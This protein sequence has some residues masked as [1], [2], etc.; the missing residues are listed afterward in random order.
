[1]LL[2]L[3]ERLVV[4]P[5]GATVPVGQGSLS[6]VLDD[7]RGGLVFQYLAPPPGVD[8]ASV[9]W[10][11]AGA[12]QPEPFISP[13]RGRWIE[14]HDVAE[15]AGSP[16]VIATR[17]RR[18]RASRR[19]VAELFLFDV[20]AG[21]GRVAFRLG[22]DR[23]A[24]GRVSHGG[25]RF[26]ISRGT[27]FELRSV[28][29]APVR[30]A[31]LPPPSEGDCVGHGVL[32]P[33]GSQMVYVQHRRPICTS[34]A[35]LVVHDL[36]RGEEVARAKVTRRGSL[37]RRVEFDGERLLVSREDTGDRGGPLR[38]SPVL[39]GEVRPDATIQIDELSLGRR[40]VP[41]RVLASFVRSSPR[42]PEGARLSP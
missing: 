29:G 28:D 6:L 38:E 5:G 40:E 7:L 21:R 14:L 19:F 9:M 8:S 42:I 18:V 27:G 26:L 25:G 37:V 1:V 2:P 39:V 12:S 16:T 20:E 35:R 17:W 22:G 10:L 36:L 11:Q 13:R 32:S 31:S 33:D 34:P 24:S 23:S 41:A 15:M 4:H 30:D 3:G